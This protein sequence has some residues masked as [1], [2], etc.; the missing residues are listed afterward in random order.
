MD[1]LTPYLINVKNAKSGVTDLLMVSVEQRE[2]R[3]RQMIKDR[4]LLG[5]D[6]DGNAIGVYSS[7]SMGAEYA[8][9][10]NRIN[11]NAGVGN[12]DLTLTGALGDGIRVR[13][14]GTKF[15]EIFSRDWKF[16][17]IVKKY[18]EY[19]FNITDEQKEALFDE[20]GGEILTKMYDIIWLA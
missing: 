8:F 20:I 18:G 12:V 2:G 5:Q 10:K 3:I 4:W 7:S 9:F 13:T 14:Y 16:G 6:P 15:I 1:Y 19:N 11:P 17:E